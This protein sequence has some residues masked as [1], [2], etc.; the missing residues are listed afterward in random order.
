MSASSTRSKVRPDGAQT[1]L[2]RPLRLMRLM[3]PLLPLRQIT[4]ACFALVLA[5][6]WAATPAHA[7]GLRFSASAD[8]T[9]SYVVNSS[10]GGRDNG[11]FIA[12]LRPG[13]TLSGRSGRVV[14]NLSYALGLSK[15]SRSYEGSDVQH[16][17][18]A[19]L[20]AEAIE[21]WLYVDVIASISQQA[22]SPFGQQSV[23]GSSL[24]NANRVEVGTLTVSPYVR[25]VLFSDVSYDVRVT[26]STTNTR[27]SIVADSSQVGA[28]ATLSSALRGT[29][30]GWALT[31]S[32][33]QV[34]YRAGSESQSD[35]YSASLSYNVDVDLT[36]ALRGGQ[37]SND[38]ASVSRTT[39][40]NY[41]G[42]I[43]WRPSPR[44]RAQ[45]DADERYFGR[46][47][48]VFIEHRM[49][50]TSFTL[51]SSR[52][53]SGGRDP[54]GLGAPVTLFQVFDRQFASIEPDPVLR[55][56]LVLA[57]LRAQG[58]DPSATVAGGFL[59]TAVTLQDRHEVSV[60]Y[61]GRRVAMT[62]QAYA[63]TNRVLDEAATGA[64]R[65][66]VR[67][68]GYQA[69]ASYRLTPDSN[70]S[71]TGSR[72]MTKATATQ[73]G[74]DLKSLSVSYGQQ[75]GRRTSASASM[76]YTVF[77]STTSPYREAAISATL[78]HRF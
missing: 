64:A 47:H 25:G 31:A 56:S 22:A 16:Q 65:E 32:S 39:Y 73:S 20:S 78:S 57:F 37:E 74:T 24:D 19:N 29:A 36:V 12:E 62:M 60:A 75:L 30:L 28:T 1:R 77:N 40:D 43:T 76:R 48:R 7:Q 44:T 58:L 17:L 61:A 54:S 38:V 18:A 46:S 50:S 55:E 67:Q 11:D 63:N 5:G 45:L 53:S 8:S 14:G 42:S 52:D 35:R 41:G 33:Q 2:M 3:R 34:D 10:L 72:L 4:A 49:A 59:N 21:R 15:H 26:G 68:H 9:L 66:T 71:L 51:S 13:F 69:N 6:G 23:D 27:R 70:V